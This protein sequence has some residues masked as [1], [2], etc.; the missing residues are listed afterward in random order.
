MGPGRTDVAVVILAAGLGK[1]MKSPKAKVLHTVCGKPMI[2]YVVDTARHIAGENVIVV[3]GHQADEVRALVTR[4]TSAF[5]AHQVRQLGTGHAVK[6]ALSVIP[7]TCRHVVVL[8]GDV[9][10]LSA[11]TLSTFVEKHCEDHRALSLIA[12]HLDNPKGY[13]RLMRD[14]EGY[15]AAIVEEADAT[16]LQKSIKLVN[17]GI[18]CIE[19]DFLRTALSAIDANNAQGEYYLTDIVAVAHRAGRT[20]GVTIGHDP[21]EFLGVNSPEDLEAVERFLVRRR[22]K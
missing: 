14:A 21:H 15:L 7:S 22:A 4:Q 13:G 20:I 8:C 11:A 5:F 3:V 19:S 10:L 12:V 9:P 6:C 16:D 17:A 18:Y 1:R 2:L